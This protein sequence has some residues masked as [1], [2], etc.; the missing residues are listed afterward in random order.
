MCLVKEEDHA[1]LVEIADFG[2]LLIQVRHHPEQEGRIHRRA[3]NQALGRENVDVSP[4]FLAGT[5]PVTDIELRLAEELFPALF[6][7]GKKRALNGADAGGGDIAVHGG[8]LGAVVPDKLKHR[9]KV[10]QIQKEQAVVIRHA[11]DD[12]QHAGLNLR[13]A[14]KTRKKR[15]THR[16]DGYADRMA[17]LAEDIP[18]AGRKSTVLKIL[19]QAEAGNPL[20]HVRGIHTGHAHAGKVPLDICEEHGHA[21]FG[22]GLGHDFHGDGLAGT[23]RA[24]DQA[25]AVGH[26]GQQVEFFVLCFRKIYFAVSVHIQISHLPQFIFLNDIITRIFSAGEAENILKRYMIPLRSINLWGM[27]RLHPYILWFLLYHRFYNKTT[28]KFIF[29]PLPTEIN[30]AI[31][32]LTM[33]RNIPASG[34]DITDH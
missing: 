8:E 12:V 21:H 9:A 26:A 19:F 28:K 25:V 11:E 32:K 34:G 10:F 24:G 16:G 2:Q 5:H 14:E 15:R 3:L 29:T 20:P 6:F 1:G 22:E 27:P 4:A 31:L 7:K 30:C 23:G 18:E 33:T 13:Q 17:G